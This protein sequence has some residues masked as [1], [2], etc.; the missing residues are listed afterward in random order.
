MNLNK[1]IYDKA[2]KG[3]KTIAIA[4]GWDERVLYAVGEIV[5]EKI[6][7][8]ILIGPEKQVRASIKKTSVDIGES[9]II[10]PATYGETQELAAALCEKRKHKGMTIDQAR[11]LVLD[12]NYFACMLAHTGKADGVASS[13]ICPTADLMRPALQILREAPV[14]SE[15]SAL[16]DPKKNRILFFT[17]ASLNIDPDAEQL[18]QIALNARDALRQLDIDPR[19]ALLSFSTHG[20]GGNNQVIQDALRLVKKRDPLLLIDGELQGDAA[21]NPDSAKRKCP[22]SVLKGDANVLV[23][24]N[25]LAA[26]ITCHTLLQLS[27]VEI[28]Y[29]FIMGMKKPIAIYGRSSPM[30]TIKNLTVACAM[31]AA[32]KK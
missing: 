20:S 17:D 1:V 10:D 21:L 5:K 2:I 18:A 3:Q 12:V 19:I 22:D 29:S 6:C 13:C 14:V 16:S 31:Q 15:V 24:P 4:E 28:L 9:R 32:D 23:C 27:D 30:K 25:L 26:N 8:I 7:N 11:D